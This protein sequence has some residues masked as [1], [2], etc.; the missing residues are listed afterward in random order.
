MTN[1]THPTAN[2]EQKAESLH[3][4]TTLAARKPELLVVGRTVTLVRGSDGPISEF[5]SFMRRRP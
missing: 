3:Q 1:L 2:L 5:F 4:R